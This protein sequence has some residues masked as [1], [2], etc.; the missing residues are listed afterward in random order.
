VSDMNWELDT[1]LEQ[2]IT[3]IAEGKA[4]VESCLLA[5]PAHADELAPLLVV[6]QELLAHPKPAISAAA[7]ARIEG[8]LF[9][10]AVA[11]GLVRRER[12]PLVLPRLLPRIVLPAWRPAYSAVA[13][14]LVVVVLLMTTLVGSANA[15]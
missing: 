10:A 5:Y 4:R 2:S 6:S 11:S 13:A 7:Q 8:Q 14:M 12:K 3:Q 15:G 1:I 9:E